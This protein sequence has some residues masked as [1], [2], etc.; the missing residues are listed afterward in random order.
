[1]EHEAGDDRD[2]HRP[3]ID[4]HRGRPGVDPPLARVQREVVGEEPQQAAQEQRGAHDAQVG[5]ARQPLAAHDHH[6]AER[7]GRDDEAR[8]RERAGAERPPGRANADERRG[9][10]DDGDERST[11]RGEIAGRGLGLGNDGH[12]DIVSL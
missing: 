9:P 1:M 5:A 4:E 11:D 8:E 2:Q 3:D 12:A 6:R 7:R 10:E